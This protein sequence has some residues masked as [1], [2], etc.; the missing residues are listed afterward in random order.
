M[1]KSEFIQ[2]RLCS[3]SFMLGSALALCAGLAI[4]WIDTRPHWD[5]TGI[6][7]GLLV[8]ATALISL[9]RVPPWLVALLVAGPMLIAELPAGPGVLIAVPAALAGAYAGAFF[10][11]RK[12]S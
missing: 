7:V 12:R 4:A 1:P 6:T 9:L 8:I 5:D 2:R 10:R 3:L 11:R